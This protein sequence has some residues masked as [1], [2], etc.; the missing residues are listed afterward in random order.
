MASA[1]E[2]DDDT[3]ARLL[4]EDARAA[5]VRYVSQGLSAML[6]RR[7]AEA[8]L[9]PNTR[10]KASIGQDYTSS[11]T[12]VLSETDILP[13]RT[14]TESGGGW[15]DGATG[16]AMMMTRENEVTGTGTG[17]ETPLLK[18]LVQD[19]QAHIRNTYHHPVISTSTEYTTTTTEN[20]TTSTGT[21]VESQLMKG[22]AQDHQVRI[23]TATDEPVPS[24]SIKRTTEGRTNPLEELVGPLPPSPPL[25]SRGR[26]AQ[27]QSISTIDSHFAANY[28]PTLDT[29]HHPDPEE[30][31]TQQQ[32]E[33][34][35]WD[36]ALEAFRD[37]QKWKQ[38]HAERMR[39]AGF[40]VEEIKKWQ[41]SNTSGKE[42]SAASLRWGK[43]GDAREWDQGK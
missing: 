17:V 28:D 6:P 26:G 5:S 20:E 29:L 25:R 1:D 31:S 30:D 19:H 41:D 11:M 34:Q 35:D 22:L 43:A 27:K 14:S 33:Q 24:P 10:N 38:K 12:P 18:V 4:A 8:A 9:R 42:K 36:M 23:G 15:M 37:R 7:P 3:V 40:G 13:E 39:E 2:L 32:Q 16:S 21:D